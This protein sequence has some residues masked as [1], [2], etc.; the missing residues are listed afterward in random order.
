MKAPYAV[1]S[2][3]LLG[4]AALGC[5]VFEPPPPATL[6]NVQQPKELPRRRRPTGPLLS[7]AMRRYGRR[8]RP[9]R[10]LRARLGTA[11]ADGPRR[12]VPRRLVLSR[13]TRD[14][15]RLAPASC[16]WRTLPR[17]WTSCGRASKAPASKWTPRRRPPRR[18]SGL[19]R[20]GTRPSS[21]T[22]FSPTCRRLTG[23]RWRAALRPP[24]HW[25]STRG[26][27]H[28]DE[29][30]GLAQT[31][32][33]RPY[34]RSPSH[35]PNWW[36]P[37]GGRLGRRYETDTNRDGW[38]VD[39]E[40]V[41]CI[42]PRVALL[43]PDTRYCRYEP[44]SGAAGFRDDGETDRAG[45]RSLGTGGDRRA[46]GL[47]PSSRPQRMPSG[48][49]ATGAHGPIRKQGRSGGA[50]SGLGRVPDRPR[51]VVAGSAVTHRRRVPD[52]DEYGRRL[53]ELPSSRTRS[54][55]LCC[56]P[57][58]ARRGKPRAGLWEKP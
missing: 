43:A 9:V 13:V 40:R 56:S 7:G 29:I 45:Y 10:P 38:A 12:Q 41:H 28:L 27:V 55:G 42:S 3:L 6:T 18:L 54:T 25:S 22:A 15:A 14:H 46:R 48:H 21:A 58:S 19:L 35:R 51:L 8:C 52:R 2:L 26:V 57:A 11:R 32:A 44:H 53:V 1:A 37:C 5:S 50:Q 30:Q 23:S 31:G 39:A 17:C 36:R 20:A 34:W 33:W 49:S 4:L 24:R 47:G 16:W